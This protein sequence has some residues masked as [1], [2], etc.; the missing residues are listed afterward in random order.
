MSAGLRLGSWS[1]RGATGLL[2][3]FVFLQIPPAAGASNLLADPGFES[4]SLVIGPQFGAIPSSVGFWTARDNPPAPPRLVD[5]PMPVHS[6]FWA[7]EIDTRTATYGEILIQDFATTFASYVW[8]FW[9]YP[10]EGYNA[11]EILY[12]WDRGVTGSGVITTRM[13]YGPAELILRA[14]DTTAS[15]PPLPTGG[16]HEVKVVANTCSLV[17][18]LYVDGVLVGSV[19]ATGGG[20]PAGMATVVFGDTGNIA[21]H[22][23]FYYD[24]ESFEEFDC[25]APTPCPLS[26]G[27]WKNHASDWPTEPDSRAAADRRQA[28][29]G[30]RVRARSGGDDN[31][32]RRRCARRVRGETAVPRSAVVV[33]RSRDGRSR[34][35]AGRVQQWGSHAGL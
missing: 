3:V 16:W 31:R 29:R 5:P 13:D 18:D 11:A 6:G 28:E 2:A 7:A 12:N 14:W 4:G 1:V 25:A 10:V 8:V 19:R 15:F 20:S 23:L 27:F 17:Q 21:K 32:R 26:H 35:R 24:D 9:V 34:G 30:E 22:G 33:R